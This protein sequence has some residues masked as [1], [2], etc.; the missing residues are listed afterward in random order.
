MT[1]YGAKDLAEAFR[2]V[3]K[4]TLVIAGELTEEQYTFSA[5]PGTRTVAQTLY[6]I[7]VISKLQEQV[8]MVEKRTT[9]A[10]FDFPAYMRNVMT[11]ESKPRTRAELIALLQTNGDHFAAWLETVSDEF[12][13]ETVGMPAGASPASKTR[14]EMLMGVKEHEM[15]HRGQ[16]MLL[17]RLVGGVPHLTRQMMER[18]AAM[19]QK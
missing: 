10:G 12:L 9:L 15:H 16:L 5:I 19:Q 6:H 18:M 2:T 7:A 17:Q 3:R 1:L 11:E 14:F 8:H 13:G 4:N